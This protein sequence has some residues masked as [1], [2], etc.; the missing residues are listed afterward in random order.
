MPHKL[1]TGIRPLRVYRILKFFNVLCHYVTVKNKREIITNFI[2]FE[3]LDGSGTTTQTNL[4]KEHFSNGGVPCRSDCEPTK[5]FIGKTIRKVLKGEESV[6]P[7]TLA[8]LFAADRH[9]H[10]YNEQEG[11]LAVCGK[12]VKVI[13]DRYLFSS[14][15]YQS[16]RFGFERVLLLN[17]S[18]PLPE[19]L[20]FLD[21]PEH[22]C[23]DRLS[24]R[25][26]LE[27]FEDTSLQ[28]QIRDNYLKAVSLYA[29]TGIKVHHLDGTLPRDELAKIIWSLLT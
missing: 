10:L 18:Y 20:F 13:S 25:E 16:M 12:G 24:V 3:G 5:G 26:E 17:E 29:D 27:I 6:A 2:V 21:V 1:F 11:I 22:I 14:L 28:Q 15:A 8:K 9:E 7:G 4:L 19:Y 23:R